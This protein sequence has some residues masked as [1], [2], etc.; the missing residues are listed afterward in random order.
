M[1]EKKDL[2][3]YFSATGVTEKIARKLAS[4][5]GADIF[6]IEPAVRYT[7][8]DL[9]W[10]DMSSR[11]TLEKLDPA[12]RPELSG[13]RIDLDSYGR[14]FVGFPIWSH[15]EPAIIDTFLEAYDFSGKKVVPFASS[16]NSEMED[17][18]SRMEVLLPDGCQVARGKRFPEDVTEQELRDWASEQ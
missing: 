15:R 9:D 8:E 2:V 18:S 10:D 16:V 5:I 4:A 12:S 3:T 14:V 1:M 6:E 11:T 17:I 7:P 13:N